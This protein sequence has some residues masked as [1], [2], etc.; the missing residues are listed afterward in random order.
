M[1]DD[2]LHTV[3][4]EGTIG[5]HGSRQLR[6]LVAVGADV[7]ID[8]VAQTPLSGL[9]VAN[10]E[11]ETLVLHLAGIDPLCRTLTH[12]S[13]ASHLYKDVLGLLEVPVEGTVERVAEERVVDTDV[14][15]CRCLP[16]DAVVAKLIAL[17]TRRQSLSAVGSGDVV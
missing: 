2:A 12:G 7:G 14:G 9:A 6:N 15:L 17:E 3:S 10:V 1:S 16:L 13:D 11:L 4:A 8:V 5:S